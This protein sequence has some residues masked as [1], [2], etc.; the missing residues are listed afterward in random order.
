MRRYLSYLK[1][2]ILHKYHVFK[3]G[4]RMRLPIIQL[5]LHDL[6]KFYLSEFKDYAYAYYDEQGNSNYAYHSGIDKAWNLHQKRNKHHWQYWICLNNSGEYTFL[7]IPEVYLREMVADMLAMGESGV[8]DD[9]LTYFKKVKDSIIMKSCD[10]VYIEKLIITY[11]G[12]G[13]D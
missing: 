13:V 4:R 1:Y 5:L 9:S 2:I 3:I 11:G 7:D 10:K 6:S 12:Y 8:G